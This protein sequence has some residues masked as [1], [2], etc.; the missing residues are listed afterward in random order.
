ML[1][2]NIDIAVLS[3]CQSV[4]EGPPNL[5]QVFAYEKCLYICIMQCYN[6][7]HLICTKDD[8]KRVISRK[9]MPFGGLNDVTLNFMSQ[10]PKY[11][12]FLP[13]NRTFKRE[14]Q[15][16]QMLITETLLSLCG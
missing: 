9:V 10:T 5:S 1:M 12:Q 13:M 8:S 3:V 14:W 6:T 2:H 11:W 16:I 4:I 7:A 15:K